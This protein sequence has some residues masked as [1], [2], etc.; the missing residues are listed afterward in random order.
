MLAI[1]SDFGQDGFGNACAH[2]HNRELHEVFFQRP[3]YG[4]DFVVRKLKYKI[5][6]VVIE[7]AQYDGRTVHKDPNTIIELNWQGCH[8]AAW[9]Q[10]QHNARWHQYVP[11]E[12]NKGK[13]KPQTHWDVW[14][15]LSV[16]ERELLGGE[17]TL[18]A[19]QAA[20]KRGA[21]T[22]WKK[23]TWEKR[24]YLALPLAD[25]LDAVG[26][27]CRHLGRLGCDLCEKHGTLSAHYSRFLDQS[28]L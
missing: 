26:L 24:G 8:V 10:A 15:V 19:I 28:G 4:P 1:D 20:C 13:H 9:Y 16:R 23:G 2:F 17:S 3:P 12:W 21:A 6:D 18:H 27:G 14:D 5:R 22:R 25:K 11:F 7:K